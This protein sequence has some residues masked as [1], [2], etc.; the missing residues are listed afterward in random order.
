ML[1]GPLPKSSEDEEAVRT[2]N[3]SSVILQFRLA[4]GSTTDA[5]RFLSGGDC[6]V[7]IWERVWAGNK[8]DTSKL[9]YDVMLAPHHCS[10]HSLSYDSWSELG[11]DAEVSE[12]ARSALGQARDG[13]YIVSSSKPISDDDSDPPCIRARREYESI[14]KGPKGS[15]VNT[16][17]HQ[18]KDGPVPMEFDVTSGGVAL[19]TVKKSASA[20][21]SAASIGVQPLWHG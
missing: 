18:D 1:I 14:L 21:R 17:T 8:D 11:D 2:K 13:A 16:A 4:H 12:D 10:W 19:R 9:D 6:E 15:F 20:T 3:D 7:A 5:C